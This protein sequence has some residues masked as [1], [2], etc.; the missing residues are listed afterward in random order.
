MLTVPAIIFVLNYFENTVEINNKNFVNFLPFIAFIF[1][2]LVDERHLFGSIFM[3]SPNYDNSISIYS[4]VTEFFN[5]IM[6]KYLEIML[7][8]NL[9]IYFHQT[10]VIVN[11]NKYKYLI[12]ILFS[13][14]FI[15]LTF[16][17]INYDHELG[18]DAAAHKWYV[19]VLPFALPT[20]QDTYEF[21]SPPLPYIFPSLIDSVCDKLVELNFLSLDC[22][23]LYGKCKL[24]QAILF[25]FILFFYIN[26]SEQI[27]DNNNEF[28]IS[29]T[30][31]VGDYICQLQNICNDSWG[32]IRYILR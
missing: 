8:N 11:K 15:V 3:E 30:Y 24:L 23:F 4:I 26:I 20:D 31:F 12:F 14:V 16:N 1:M 5:N 2:L 10:L 25:I 19:E 18:Y 27:F 9:K 17:L 29:F 22:T 32:A 7:T 28:L 6:K 13:L 21:F